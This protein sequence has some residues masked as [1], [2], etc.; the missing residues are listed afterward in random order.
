MTLA[1]DMCEKFRSDALHYSSVDLKYKKK[2]KNRARG[3]RAQR[4]MESTLLLQRMRSPQTIKKPR[5]QLSLIET[6]VREI[7]VPPDL[8]AR[9]V[10]GGKGW[11]AFK[12][13]I[14]RSRNITTQH[15]RCRA[16]KRMNMAQ[17]KKAIELIFQGK[18]PAAVQRAN[19]TGTDMRFFMGA[20]KNYIRPHKRLQGVIPVESSFV[21]HSIYGSNNIAEKCKLSMFRCDMFF[22]L[23]DS[24][25]TFDG[26]IGLDLVKQV[27]AG[28]KAGVV[29][30]KINESQL[31]EEQINRG[32]TT[33]QLPTNTR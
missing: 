6:R 28:G 1:T 18:V 16:S 3:D 26:I 15:K 5:T 27:G 33:K 8:T 11:I 14:Q 25:S 22:F 29:V 21:V 20:S 7:S 17:I 31:H 9:Q 13:A 4:P 10:K 30:L 24:L 23:L 32:I 2:A 19:N 12:L